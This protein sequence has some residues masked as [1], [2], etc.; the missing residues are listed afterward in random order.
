MNYFIKRGDQEYGPYTLAVLQQ[1]VAQGN[2][3]LQDLARSEGMSDWVPV[4]K[5]IGNVSV[6]PVPST[7]G[8]AA[9]LPADMPLPPNLHWG[10]VLALGIVTIG[11]FFAIWAF[12]Q[13]VWVKK[14]RP[15]N[16]ALYY[17]LGY[18]ACI[19]IAVAIGSPGGALFRLAA[20]ILMIMAMFSMKADIE[21]YYSMLNPSGL[22]L[23]SVLTFFLG[24]IY[25]QYHLPEIRELSQQARVATAA[26]GRLA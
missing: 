11:I 18:V 20:I 1:Y 17:L 4:T 13:A 10:I 3:S 2:I 8:G 25:L 23:S 16:R 7:Y 24:V 9:S 6:T 12:V 15:E 26:A 5:I 22:Q 14:V 21:E 19:V